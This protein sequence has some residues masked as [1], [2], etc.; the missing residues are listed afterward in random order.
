MGDRVKAEGAVVAGIKT[1]ACITRPITFYAATRDT[2]ASHLLMGTWGVTFTLA[3]VGKW[4]GHSDAKVTERYARVAEEHLHG[5]VAKLSRRD[6]ETP[7]FLGHARMVPVPNSPVDSAARDTG[8]EP[9]TFGS[10]G[11]RSPGPNSS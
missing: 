3:E 6:P 8:F 9:V 5:K 2:C 7:H 4:L 11:L 10:G 1:R